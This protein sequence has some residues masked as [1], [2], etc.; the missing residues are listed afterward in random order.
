MRPHVSGTGD[1]GVGIISYLDNAEPVRAVTIDSPVVEANLSGR[2]VSVVGGEN[3]TYRNIKVTGS[4]A[5]AVYVATEG[6]F[7]TRGC[8]GVRIL[9]GSVTNANTRTDIGHGAVVL[10]VYTRLMPSTTHSL[11]NGSQSSTKPVQEIVIAVEPNE[12]P[13]LTE[14]IAVGA[15][16]V[17]VARSGL[18]EETHETKISTEQQEAPKV[19][20]IETINGRQRNQVAVQLPKPVKPEPTTE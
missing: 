5:A 18:P 11:T 7:N 1:D 4:P 14:A 12:V 13:K 2:G 19:R 9:G 10:P 15:E 8:R 20:M 17:A 3:I 16:L 6:A